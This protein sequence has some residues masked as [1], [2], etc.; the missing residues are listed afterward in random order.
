VNVAGVA[1]DAL[2]EAGEVVPVPQ[3]RETVTEAAELSEKSLR[4]LKVA[5]FRVLTIVQE[6]VPPT[7][8]ATLVQAASFLV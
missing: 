1:S 4:T 6:A 5:V 8:M 3:E 7:E 2:A